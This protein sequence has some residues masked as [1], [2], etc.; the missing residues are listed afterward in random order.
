MTRI[1]SSLNKLMLDKRVL[2]PES[3]VILCR[4]KDLDDGNW[5]FAYTTDI[6]TSFYLKSVR[7]WYSCKDPTAVGE[8]QSRLYYGKGRP[9]TDTDM[10]NWERFMP[11][12]GRESIH[13]LQVFLGNTYF[14]FTMNQKFDGMGWRF[15]LEGRTDPGTDAKIIAA[16]EIAEI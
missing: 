10:E 12:M 6:G 9:P 16:F 11:V 3:R 4:V 15:G 7:L 2:I 8:I 13:T 1:A 5:H 14:E